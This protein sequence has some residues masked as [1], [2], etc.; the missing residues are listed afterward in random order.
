M[1]FTRAGG[2]AHNPAVT[3]APR[4]L[5]EL[6]AR[7][8][9]L[10]SLCLRSMSLA[11]DQGLTNADTVWPTEVLDALG[12]YYGPGSDLAAQELKEGVGH[13]LDQQQDL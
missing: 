13:G 8:S 10:K 1:T 6:R 11:P 7:V 9:A 5:T 12:I 2:A 3:T 4:E